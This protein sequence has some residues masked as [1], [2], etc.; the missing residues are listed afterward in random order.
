MNGGPVQIVGD[1]GPAIDG[2]SVLY[3]GV[4]GSGY[5]SSRHLFPVVEYSPSETPSAQKAHH[6]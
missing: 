1:M 2:L 5:C 4:W 6:N 3:L